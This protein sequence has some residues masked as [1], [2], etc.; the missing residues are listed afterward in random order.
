MDIIV[1]SSIRG[2]PNARLHISNVQVLLQVHEH[3]TKVGA[4]L[5]VGV[6]VTPVTPVVRKC[7]KCL[8]LWKI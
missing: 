6:T 4:F 2:Y 1:I 8:P 5:W 3:S 7:T